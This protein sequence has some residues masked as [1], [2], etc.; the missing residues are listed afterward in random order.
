MLHAVVE[1]ET[2]AEDG[3]AFMCLCEL[4]NR[5]FGNWLEP[6]SA[7]CLLPLH[8]VTLSFSSLGSEFLIRFGVYSGNPGSS[9][10]MLITR[11][12]ARM[13]CRIC[14]STNLWV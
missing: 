14:Q 3:F 4:D 7:Y 8:S 5:L 11:C 1:M 9:T 6:F 13:L 2:V 10:F 12:I